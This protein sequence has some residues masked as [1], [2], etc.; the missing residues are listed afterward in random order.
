V[1]LSVDVNTP[2]YSSSMQWPALECMWLPLELRMCYR[3]TDCSEVFHRP[4]T[5]RITSL[6]YGKHLTHNQW[7]LVMNFSVQL[8][9]LEQCFTYLPS[10]FFRLL[11][12]SC[13]LGTGD[14]A[15]GWRSWPLQS[16]AEIVNV[17]SYSHSTRSPFLTWLS[18]RAQS[19]RWSSF[20]KWVWFNESHTALFIFTFCFIYSIYSWYKKGVL[21]QVKTK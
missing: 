16:S 5:A 2:Q 4:L 11:G 21:Y 13:I 12:S 17:W 20:G 8:R 3:A 7:S 14:K 6:P 15:A 10:F 19:G 18:R 9:K 1:W